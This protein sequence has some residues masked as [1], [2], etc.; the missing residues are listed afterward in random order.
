MYWEDDFDGSGR[1]L[2]RALEL[3]PTS[4]EAQRF[5]AM[6]LKIAGRS[7]EALD[8]MRR[9]V[10]QQATVAAAH[11]THGDIL[12]TLGRYD[13]AI[14]PLRQALKLNPRYD[15]ALE[16]LAMA[17][18]RAGLPAE[19]ASARRA[20]LGQRG[21]EL[22]LVALD[23][24][25]KQHGWTHAREADLERELADLL[26]RAQRDDPFRDVGTSRQPSDSIIITLAE[27]GRWTEAMDWVE[28]GFH[29]RPG[30]LRRVLRDMPF[31]PGGLAIDPRYAPMLRMAGLE[32]L[33]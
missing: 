33:L 24:D 10:V 9:V 21:L 14:G 29:R 11:N 7:Q 8:F 18:H 12:M 30:R 25:L 17:S 6:W 23:V 3:D 4:P 32:E 22:R 1:A 13:E 15:A 16:R 31:N 5:Y 2:T 26:T 19:A 28:K 20:L 27:L